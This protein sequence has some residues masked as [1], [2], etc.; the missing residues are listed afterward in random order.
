MATRRRR[1][2]RQL[3]EEERA[4]W[5]TVADTVVP[6]MPDK[7]PETEPASRASDED[8]PAEVGRPA[9]S[10]AHPKITPVPKPAVQRSSA[11][12]RVAPIER[13]TAQRIARGTIAIDARLDLHGLRQ[14]AA[15]R[16]LKSFLIAAH[17]RG[18]RI[19]LVITGKGSSGDGDEAGVLRRQVP[20]WLETPDLRAI[21]TGISVAH[22]SHGGH[23]ALY[24]QIRRR[25]TG[26]G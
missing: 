25:V 17:T 18:D 21:V 20:K 8:K 26:L 24:V 23:G 10:D 1:F 22:R 14:Q 5:R 16:A 6:R 4:L 3:S 12:S 2:P 11:A 13:R 15:H 7:R 19:V 9:A